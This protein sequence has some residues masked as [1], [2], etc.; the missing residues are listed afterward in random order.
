MLLLNDDL[1]TMTGRYKWR[2]TEKNI[3]MSIIKK[4]ARKLKAPENNLILL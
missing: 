3:L 1:L 2:K 4:K